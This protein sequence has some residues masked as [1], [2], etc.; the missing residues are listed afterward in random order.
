[1]L[2]TWDL[3]SFGFMLK[4]HVMSLLQKIGHVMNLLHKV[5]N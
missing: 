1:M 5:H 3:F 2:L 4:G